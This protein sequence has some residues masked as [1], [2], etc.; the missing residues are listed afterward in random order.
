[1]RQFM[2]PVLQNPSQPRN[3]GVMAHIGALCFDMM[4][5]AVPSLVVWCVQMR[6]HAC[7]ARVLA[8]RPF[9]LRQSAV[10][11]PLHRGGLWRYLQ[12]V[13]LCMDARGLARAL[14]QWYLSQTCGFGRLTLAP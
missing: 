9:T 7:S 13:R 5:L 10:P 11:A 8:R 3:D 2:L 12:S 6:V 1:M 4:K 14:L